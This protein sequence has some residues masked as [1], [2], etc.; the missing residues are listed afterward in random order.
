MSQDTALP[1]FDFSEADGQHINIYNY[2]T[3]DQYTNNDQNANNY[4]MAGQPSQSF[5]SS[6]TNFPSSHHPQYD[7][8]LVHLGRE[9]QYG[10][11]G[12]LQDG[13]L[14]AP[15]EWFNEFNLNGGSISDLD[16]TFFF[17]PPQSS[18]TQLATPSMIDDLRPQQLEKSRQVQPISQ[19]PSG[20]VLLSPA[21]GLPQAPAPIKLEPSEGDPAISTPPNTTDGILK[22]KNR[23]DAI[24]RLRHVPT[25]M[26][27]SPAEDVTFPRTDGDRQHYAQQL[28]TALINRDN[29]EDKP[30]RTYNKRAKRANG[31]EFYW[32]EDMEKVCWD[33]VD[34]TERFHRDG[35]SVLNIHDHSFHKEIIEPTREWSFGKRI[36]VLI[37]VMTSFKSRCNKLMK[38]GVLDHYIA[39]P[40]EILKNCR[41]NLRNN[42]R[43]QDVL[44]VGYKALD[45]SAKNQVPAKVVDANSVA[46]PFRNPNQGQAQLPS[47][48]APQMPIMQTPNVE[49]QAPGLSTTADSEAQVS[50]T[51]PGLPITPEAPKFPALSHRPF[52]NLATYES[53]TSTI[54]VPS[55]SESKGS[56]PTPKDAENLVSPNTEIFTPTNAP[57]IARVNRPMMKKRPGE[58]DLEDNDNAA[59]D[60]LSPSQKRACGNTGPDHRPKLMPKA[61]R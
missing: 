58:V 9:Y 20:G 61:T 25:W 10:D 15:R 44:K 47:P 38:G 42:N 19:Q 3:G 5:L 1:H 4:N 54:P 40:G 36:G 59:R 46:S 37:E 35:P 2:N 28:F 48:H 7:N 52:Y 31:E 16:P 34:L 50:Y 18:A 51:P 17:N 60:S 12:L 24:N 57:E 45:K 39:N 13:Q 8:G 21:S 27:P 33:I 53:S 23:A 43:R 29:V 6:N 26:P 30:G 11:Q 41:N 55:T 56:I 49:S 22:S 14:D 32:V